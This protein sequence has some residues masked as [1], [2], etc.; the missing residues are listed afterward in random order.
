MKNPLQYK[1]MLCLLASV[2]LSVAIFKAQD[3]RA[4][5]RLTEQSIEAFYEQ[6]AAVQML[7][8]DVTIE[9]LERHLHKDATT[10]LFMITHMQGAPSQKQE[11]TYTRSELLQETK[12]GKEV[13]EIKSVENK[14]I[15]IKIASD[16]RSAKVKDSTH[17][18]FHL[19]IP[20]PQGIVPMRSEQSMFCDGVVVLGPGDVIQARESVCHAEVNIEP[21]K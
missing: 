8:T 17:S 9:F 12:K 7:G 16:G 18:V 3:A 6:S 5:S 21:L 19:D 2:L 20:V 14:V 13:G 10:K 4:E 1:A 15:S 11:N